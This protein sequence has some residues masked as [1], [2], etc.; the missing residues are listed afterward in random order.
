VITPDGLLVAG[1]ARGDDDGVVVLHLDVAV[2]VDRDARVPPSARP[3][4]RREH[5]H[6]LGRKPDFR[7]GNLHAAGD[8]EVAEPL[9]DLRV[10][11]HP[12]AHERDL[13]VELRRQIHEDLHPVDARGKCGDDDAAGGAREDLFERL[14]HFGFRARE[15]LAIDVRAVGEQREHAL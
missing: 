4:I 1:I 2:I 6:V 15:A 5:E 14:N 3:A 8:L 10:L 7:I 11:H 13:A 9:R 12:A